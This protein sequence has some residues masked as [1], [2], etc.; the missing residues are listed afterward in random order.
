MIKYTGGK[1]ISTVTHIPFNINN[2]DWNLDKDLGHGFEDYIYKIIVKVLGAT[3]SSNIDVYQ[4]KP[5]RDGGRD[6]IIESTKKFELFGIDFSLKGKDKIKI[7]IECKS[8]NQDIVSYDKFAKNVIIAGQ[9]KVD[10]LLLVTNKTIT[11]HTFYSACENASK[12]GYEFILIDQYILYNYLKNYQLDKWKLD[13]VDIGKSKIVI[14]YQTDKGSYN[15]IPCMDLYL[16]CRNYSDDIAECEIELVTDWNWK[17]CS[18]KAPFILEKN[19]GK[20]IKLKLFKEF[21]EGLDDIVLQLSLNNHLN[22]IKL[23]GDDLSYDFELPLSGE[24]HKN[25]ISQTEETLNF[26]SSF[27]WINLYGEA[28]VGKTRITNELNKLFLSRSIRTISCS[29]VKSH[30]ESTF[31]SIL[32]KTSKILKTHLDSS[33]LLELLYDIADDFLWTVLFVEDIHNADKEFI[34]MLDLVIKKGNIDL[35]VILITTGR[36]DY[37]VFNEDYFSL[38]EK[39]NNKDNSYI[40]NYFVEPFTDEECTNLIKRTIKD[41]PEEALDK[42][43]KL[44]NNNPFYLVH[45][46][47]YLLEIKLVNLLNRNTVGIPNVLTFAEK[48]YIPKAVEELLEKRYQ[49]LKNYELGRRC[50]NFLKTAALFGLHFP[51]QLLYHYFAENEYSNLEILFKGHFIASL[52]D[53]MFR[54]D[55]ETIYLFLKNKVFHKGQRQS[56]YNKI[57]LNK[58]IFDIYDNLKQGVI[59]Y[60]LKKFKEAKQCFNVPVYEIEYMDNLSSENISVEYFEYFDYIYEIFRT[61]KKLL[62]M[63]KTIQAKIYVAMHNLSLGQATQAFEDSFSLIANYH[64]ND[65]TFLL[66]IKQ[67]QASF[68]LHI[69]RIAEARGIMNGLLAKERMSKDIFSDEI[70]FNLFERASSLY[71]HSNHTQPAIEYNKLAFQLAEQMNN[72]KLKALAKINEAKLYFFSNTAKSYD[73]MLEAKEYL[74]KS[75]VPRINCHNEIGILTAD[76]I[77]GNYSK[78]NI[79]LYIERAQNLLK[80]SIEV[81]YPLDIIRSHFI[82]AILN[83]LTS[84]K[85]LEISKKHL[86]FGIDASVRYGILKLMGNLYNLKALIGIY[87]GQNTDDIAATFKTMIDYLN[88]E[89]LLFLGNLD[90]SY[91]NIILLTNYLIFLDDYALESQK[92]QFLSQITYYG[93]RSVCDFQCSRHVDCQY[94]CSKN[95]ETFQKNFENVKE[96][97]L[98]LVNPRYKFPF[99]MDKYFYPIYL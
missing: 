73:L 8:T 25:I 47:E 84:D 71:I 79:E 83:F 70:R 39:I 42:L 65:E 63:K 11:P 5:T 1:M 35:S 94:T 16:F 28:G 77:L 64:N 10:Y 78:E 95:I 30:K 24:I 32:D 51:K 88:Q 56:L 22:S 43:H 87:E 33:N 57:Y 58:N 2:Q 74:N 86:T 54:F 44:S 49:I 99:I 69:G 91:S 37:T 13:E 18:N 20:C 50:Q 36:D 29:C 75:M 98:L 92:Y 7:Y 60:N 90:F 59:L 26:L 4:T 3:F 82:L 76:I 9:D 38:L 31:T 97:S 17:I 62:F 93:Y 96:G 68:Y 27:S 15:R 61:E 67:L 52:D 12:S 34:K 53:E 6:V 85:N 19:K 81:N 40:Y 46:I 41:M 80:N 14:S 48:L 55:H 23:Q 45:F 21:S 66:D 72:D 89:D